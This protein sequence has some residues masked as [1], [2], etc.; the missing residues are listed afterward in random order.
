MT[1]TIGIIGLGQ[2]GASIGLALKARGGVDRVLGHT[3]DAADSAHG[4][5]DGRNRCRRG[6]EGSC[7]GFGCHLPVHTA[8]R[9]ASYAGEASSRG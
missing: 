7:P 5:G 1:T 2:I 3:R 9:D 6:T 4:F 8:G